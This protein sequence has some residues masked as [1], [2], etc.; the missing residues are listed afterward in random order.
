MNAKDAIFNIYGFADRIVEKYLEGLSDADLLVR[1]VEGMNHMAWQL[2]HLIVAERTLLDS[3]KP[4]ASPPLPAGFEEAHGR[5][6]GSTGS[7]D[8]NRFSTKAHYLELLKIQREATKAVV[9][10]MSPEELDTPSIEK[11]RSRVPTFGAV[12]L[13]IGSHYVMHS[14]QWVAVRRKL[15]L[16]VAI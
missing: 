7:D 15:G 11:L 10:E 1:P 6:P 4:G 14:G 8:P 2:G 9:A 3:V 16:P 5:E 12:L 13:L